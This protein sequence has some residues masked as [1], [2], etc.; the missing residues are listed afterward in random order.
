M[1]FALFRRGSKQQLL[2]TPILPVHLRP[3]FSHTPSP[4]TS[5]FKQTP[6]TPPPSPTNYGT[7]TAPCM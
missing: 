5:N 3:N 1:K 4:W 2:K 7:T 6:L